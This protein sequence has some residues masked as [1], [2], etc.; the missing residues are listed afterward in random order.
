MTADP[1]TTVNARTLDGLLRRIGRYL[2]EHA[3]DRQWAYQPDHPATLLS[4]AEE[5]LSELGRRTGL[6]IFPPP[7]RRE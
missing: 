2:H 6:I 7:V 4:E 3:G 5:M 1:N